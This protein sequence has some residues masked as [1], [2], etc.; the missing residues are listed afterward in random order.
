M[1]ILDNFLNPETDSEEKLSDGMCR[2]RAE[3]E[4]GC[5]EG[6]MIIPPRLEALPRDLFWLVFASTEEM[7]F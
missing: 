4:R 6:V 2:E 5:H 3:K 1:I 7:Y